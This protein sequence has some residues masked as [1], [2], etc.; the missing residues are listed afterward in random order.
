M[1]QDWIIDCLKY[2]LY[3]HF[4]HTKMVFEHKLYDIYTDIQQIRKFHRKCNC[5][6]LLVLIIS[7]DSGNSNLNKS[8]FYLLQNKKYHWFWVT[9]SKKVK[10]GK[11]GNSQHWT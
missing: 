3:F 5:L 11:N 2:S 8:H 1:I 4:S 7:K 10:L 6:V 9:H